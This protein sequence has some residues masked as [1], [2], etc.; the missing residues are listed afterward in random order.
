[1][2]TPARV[3]IA[4]AALYALFFGWYTSFGGPLTPEEIEK[5]M[6]II[7]E[8]AEDP[9]RLE[10]WRAFMESDTGD[11][12]VM[13][14]ALHLRDAPRAGEGVAPGETSAEVMSRYTEPFMRAAIPRASHPIFYGRAAAGAVDSACALNASS[15]VVQ[16]RSSPPTQSFSSVKCCSLNRYTRTRLSPAW[17]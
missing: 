11:D 12:F 13:V 1:M 10:V 16:K 8:R 9:S 14:N 4:L 5:Y 2:F 15:C 17:R 6:G 7:A 3:W